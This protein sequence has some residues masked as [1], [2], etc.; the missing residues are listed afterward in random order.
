MLRLFPIAPLL[1]LACFISTPRAEAGLVQVT[2]SG[3]IHETGGAPQEIGISLAPLKADGRP[4]S[5]TMNLHLAEHTSARDLAE[6]VA[7]R[8]LS[9]GFGPRAWVSGP[10]GAGSGS[11]AH[12]FLESPSSLVLRLSGGINGNVTLCEDAP[13]SIKVLPP[14][15]APEALELSMAFSTRHP[16][17]ETHGRHE[18]KL[19]LSPVNTSAQ[20]SKKLSAKALAAGWLGTRP[21]LE[22][23]KFHKRSDGSLIQG[24][25]I[26]LWTDGD[27]G[28]RV[29][30]P[31]Y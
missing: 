4:A 8:F 29:E 14:R 21:T 27:W 1:F 12:L 15:L 16:H 19:E 13:E 6:L 3:E 18:I 9:S 5:W 25:S 2:L 7:R 17:S 20:A 28:L 24:C 22:T 31:A 10:P 11:I 26:S 30:L 23:Y